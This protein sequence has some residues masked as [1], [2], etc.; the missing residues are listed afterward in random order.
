MTLIRK[1][2][3]KMSSYTMT[4]KNCLEYWT[5]S[6][7][8]NTKDLIEKGRKELFNFDY[9]IF[10]ENYRKVFETHFIRNFFMREIGF[11]S[12][13]AF[14]FHLE[15]WLMINM[16]YFNR[17]FES[18]LLKFDPLS[19]TKVDVTHN[20][21][22]DRT[23]NDSRESNVSSTSSGKADRSANTDSNS[24]VSTDNFNRDI[25][26][27]TPDNRLNLTANDGEGILEYAS[28]IEE[29]TENNKAD[30]SGNTK[31]TENSS[32]SSQDDVNQNDKVNS[33]INDIEDFIQHRAG[34]IGDQSYSKML[35]EYRQSFIR[36]EQ[37]MFKEMQQLFMLVY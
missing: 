36:I 8:I 14:K 3:N 31:S 27:D 26:A 2:E 15:T 20:K 35:Q 33:S 34:K 17:L 4:L 1:E 29:E 37:Q 25:V 22:N 32:V 21:K 23:Q 11:E 18:E 6:D 24:T 30:S 16:P 10:D 13:G 7:T 5:A 28:K 12:E 19:N 9:E